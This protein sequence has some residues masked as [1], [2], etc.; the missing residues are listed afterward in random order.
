MQ[1]SLDIKENTNIK[2]GQKG[3]KRKGRDNNIKIR[4]IRDTR[5]TSPWDFEGSIPSKLDIVTIYDDTLDAGD[6]SIV[7]YDLPNDT[8]SIIIER[9][10]SLEEFIGNI[11]KNWDRFQRELEKLSLYEYKY[12]IIEDDL[13]NA[14]S[15][16]KSSRTYFNM[17]PEFIISRISD[18]NI[19][20][21]VSTHFLT[22]KYYAQRYALNLFKYVV[23]K[24]NSYDD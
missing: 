12:I 16:Y 19:R 14:Y 11:G 10:R 24:D 2:K 17:P 7:G 3:V 4:I 1:E 15:R 20:Y 13:H 9:K 6:Y 5:E 8:C 22:Q 21:G 18:I 23:T